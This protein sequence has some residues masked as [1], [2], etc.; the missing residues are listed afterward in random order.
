[1]VE[2]AYERTGRRQEAS[3]QST[4]RFVIPVEAHWSD[5]AKTISSSPTAFLSRLLLCLRESFAARFTPS[6]VPIRVPNSRT[7]MFRASLA[8]QRL[9]IGSKRLAHIQR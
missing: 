9:A 1:M 7:S 5:M 3:A 6:L 8:A 2:A 4:Q